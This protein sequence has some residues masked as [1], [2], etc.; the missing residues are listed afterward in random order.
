MPNIHVLEQLLRDV[1]EEGRRHHSALMRSLRGI[2]NNGDGERGIVYWRESREGRDV[3][4][5]RVSARGGIDLLRG[6]GFSG[7]SVA[8]EQSALAS[9]IEHNRFQHLLHLRSG[10]GRDDAV[11][12]RRTKHYF[13]QSRFGLSLHCTRNHARRV[14][15][16]IV[17][18][19]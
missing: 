18:D 1:G 4:T 9:A 19:G 2:Q 12:L 17:G 6:P 7:G 10:Q 11:L 14:V 13:A 16:A 15:H 5:M 8:I 3:L